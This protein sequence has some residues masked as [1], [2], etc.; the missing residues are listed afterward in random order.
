MPVSN[1]QARRIAERL[2]AG[3]TPAERAEEL[4]VRLPEEFP[5]PPRM[6]SSF[7]LTPAAVAERRA[8]LAAQGIVTDRLAA[9]DAQVAP[10]SLRGNI[11]SLVGFALVPVGVIGPL[12]IRGT[13]ANGDFYV[14]LATTEGALVASY[15][16]G[17]Y[18]ISRSGGAAVMCLME[19]VMRA[20]CFVFDDMHRAALFVAWA[21]QQFD[22][23]QD[24]VRTTSRHCQ[25]LDCQSTVVGREVYLGFEFATGDAAGQNMVTLATDAICRHLLERAPV[26]PA[27]WFVEGN[28]SGDKKATL[29]AFA[30]ARG[31][32]VVA[33]V[34]VP[35]ALIRHVLHTEPE[36][37]A[38]YWQASIMGG[39]QSGSIGVQGH[40]ANA[41]AA[42]FIACGQ[43]AA[44]VSEA[45]VGMTRIDVTA[46][47]DLYAAVSL[48]N[49]IVGTVGGGT[50]LPVARECLAMLGCTGQ[51]GSRKLAEICAAAAL[52]GEIS[53]GGAMAAGDFAKAHASRGRKPAGA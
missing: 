26:K 6:P 36:D 4:R 39:V 20:P 21:V 38:R 45:A 15:D 47:G 34:T 18:L 22:T 52:A 19:S 37:L 13:N 40:F 3:R 10:G 1:D 2:L 30:R 16:R 25:V 24:V 41:L 23:L 33:D 51:G 35:R 31:K 28:M 46:S 5:L 50:H 12:R 42:I 53:I 29:M 32:K 11:E 49:L 43:D 7:E 17:A 8:M 9:A 27:I 44:C 48:P 14:P